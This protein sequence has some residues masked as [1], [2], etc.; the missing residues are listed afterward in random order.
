VGDSWRKRWDS[1]RLFTPAKFD[2]IDGMPFPAPPNSFPTKNQMA[3]YLESYVRRFNLPVRTGAHVTELYRRGD[4]LVV[5][6]GDTEIEAENVIVAM[7]LY[8]KHVVPSFAAE[9]DPAIVQFHSCDYRNPE[10]LRAGDVLLVGAGNSGAE[11]AMELSKSH[12]IFLSG[13]DVGHVPFRIE[14]LAARLIL[15]RLVLRVFFHRIATIR[16]PIG[17]RMI[18]KGFGHGLPW[19]RTKPI[20]LQTAGVQRMARVVGVRDG[21]PMLEDGRVLDV[22]NV[23]WCTGFHPGF[24]WIKLPIFDDHGLPIHER[25][26]V[27]REPGLYFAGLAFT[28]SAS[29]TMIHGVSRDARYIADAIAVRSHHGRAEIPVTAA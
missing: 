4:K 7:A 18:A 1:L 28:Y 10:Q 9:L 14:S 5:R 29:S 23:I 13:R 17:R 11:I 20:D 16:T 19:I 12:R 22:A 25:G 15:L 3:D 26:V 27:T 21:K 8:Q 6:A 2:A 24:S